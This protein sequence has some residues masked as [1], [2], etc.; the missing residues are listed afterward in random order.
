[1]YSKINRLLTLYPVL[2][3][4]AL[5]RRQSLLFGGTT[6]RPWFILFVA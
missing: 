6:K 4:I 1:M 2:C 5:A 3:E